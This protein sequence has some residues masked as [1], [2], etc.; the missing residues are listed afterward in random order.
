MCA[1]SAVLAIWPEGLWCVTR[2]HTHAQEGNA[3]SQTPQITFLGPCTD[4]KKKNRKRRM[5][6]ERT[7]QIFP[8]VALTIIRQNTGEPSRPSIT[9]TATPR[10]ELVSRWLQAFIWRKA[11]YVTPNIAITHALDLGRV[12]KGRI[13]CLVTCR[14]SKHR[15]CDV[16]RQSESNTHMSTG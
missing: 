11:F 4:K 16:P 5:H 9:H 14:E 10:K 3:K 8:A 2:T 12:T 13:C 7:R 6:G 1:T 15:I